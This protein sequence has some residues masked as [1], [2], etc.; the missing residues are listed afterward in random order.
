[1]RTVELYAAV[2]RAVFV[3]GI[4]QCKTLG[5]FRALLQSLSV[6]HPEFGAERFRSG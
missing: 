3:Q 6:I 4:S 2:G 5:G 1:M